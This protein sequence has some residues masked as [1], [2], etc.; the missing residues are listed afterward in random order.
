MVKSWSACSAAVFI[1]RLRGGV[2]YQ[3]SVLTA[4]FVLVCK[5]LSLRRGSGS[6]W[7]PPGSLVPILQGLGAEGFGK[8][9]WV[10]S[11]ML[12]HL[13]G[14]PRAHGPARLVPAL[15]WQPR[16]EKG[17]RELVC[18]ERVG[19]RKAGNGEVLIQ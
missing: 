12:W 2:N 13:P 10:L 16:G 4:G 7:C 11:C 17:R 18:G 5:S 9:P 14:E 19:V 6:C 15:I 3:G 8:A 1:P